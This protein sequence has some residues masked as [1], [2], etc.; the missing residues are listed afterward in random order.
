MNRPRQHTPHGLRRLSLGY[1]GHMGVGVQG[2]AGAVMPQYPRDGLDVQSMRLPEFS[3][4]R[5]VCFQRENGLR[6][7]KVP[8]PNPCPYRGAGKNGRHAFPCRRPQLTI[9]RRPF[10]CGSFPL[11]RPLHSGILKATGREFPE[12]RLTASRGR[13]RND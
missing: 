9:Q 2:E 4:S 10:R 1:G 5:M 6:F 7:F 12:I 13:D 11:Y 8:D 3:C